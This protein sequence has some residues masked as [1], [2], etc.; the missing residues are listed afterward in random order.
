MS[1]DQIMAE[2]HHRRPRSL[3][4]TDSP[5][6]ISYVVKRDH[7][8][9]HT[10]FGNL[11]AYQIC[12]QLNMCKYKPLGINIVCKFINGVEV[13]KT[14]KNNSKKETKISYAWYSLFKNM[15][16]EEIIK[17]I[18]NVWLDPSYHFYIEYLEN[19]TPEKGP[20]F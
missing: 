5:E 3:N 7:L 9:W 13:Y 8:N 19:Q 6:N 14:G 10:L 1:R 17:Y 16:F 11:N 15:E 4:G 18:N 2:E 20:V 12:K